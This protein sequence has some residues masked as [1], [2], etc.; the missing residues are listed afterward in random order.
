MG[1]GYIADAFDDTYRVMLP[2]E[3]ARRA[4]PHRAFW[5]SARD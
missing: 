4:K 3:S 5:A 2:Y 1:A